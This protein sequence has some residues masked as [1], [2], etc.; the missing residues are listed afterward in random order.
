[1]NMC[2]GG[3]RE[4]ATKMSGLYRKEPLGKGHPGPRAG[5]LRVGA[6]YASHTL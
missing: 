2:R 1:M 4:R 3:H 6:G 5:K